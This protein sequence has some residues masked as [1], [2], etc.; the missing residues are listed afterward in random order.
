MS[1][2]LQTIVGDAIPS[3]NDYLAQ[4]L[5][6]NPLEIP[7]IPI[8]EIGIS[9]RSNLPGVAGVGK[10]S[11]DGFGSFVELGSDFYLDAVPYSRARSASLLSNSTERVPPRMRSCDYT[12]YDSTIYQ[13][14]LDSHELLFPVYRR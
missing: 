12:I 10:P 13:W 2:A 14:A 11:A 6:A 8:A 4:T 7:D 5:A 1:K 3:L 9:L